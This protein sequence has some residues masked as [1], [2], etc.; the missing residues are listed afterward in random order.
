[1]CGL[2]PVLYNFQIKWIIISMVAH[3][4]INAGTG[5]SGERG[6]IWTSCW[7]VR[8]AG[9]ISHTFRK[10]GDTATG[11]VPS[12][13]EYRYMT[14]WIAVN[15]DLKNQCCGSGLI[16]SGSRSGSIIFPQS[17]SVLRI[18]IRDP[19]FFYPLDPGWIFSGSRISDPASFLMKFSYNIF[20]IHV[21]LSL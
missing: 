12:L 2:V 11:T 16:Y 14:I 21:M 17:G 13:R 19:V 1:M 20:R 6:A 3:K 4:L 7:S 5:Y 15:V 8:P 9:C 18:R 10:G